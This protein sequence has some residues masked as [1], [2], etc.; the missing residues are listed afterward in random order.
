MNNELF[1]EIVMISWLLSS[2]VVL[3]IQNIGV[4]LKLGIVFKL[5]LLSKCIPPQG[6]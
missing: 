4:F 5:K 3:L 6:P 1:P 2:L